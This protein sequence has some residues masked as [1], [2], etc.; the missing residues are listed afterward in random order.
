MDIFAIRKP[1][2]NCNLKNRANGHTLK[3][4]WELKY[5]EHW[6]FRLRPCDHH[7]HH[8]HLMDSCVASEASTAAGRTTR[9]RLCSFPMVATHCSL[10]SFFVLW[11]CFRSSKNTKNVLINVYVFFV[12]MWESRQLIKSGLESFKMSAIGNKSGKDGRMTVGAS[13]KG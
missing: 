1:N 2:E 6:K 10:I 7:H 13:S 5:F 8:H 12:L 3:Q 9:R 4:Q 11:V